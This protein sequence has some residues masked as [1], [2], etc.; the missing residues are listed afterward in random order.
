M[1]R[2]CSVTTS[3]ASSC[4]KIDFFSFELRDFSILISEVVA[5]FGGIFAIFAIV[6]SMSFVFISICFAFLLK[7]SFLL[8]A[9]SSKTSI[10]LSGKYLSV[11]KRELSST[12][13]DTA[14]SEYVTLWNFSYLDVSPFIIAFAF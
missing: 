1:I 12:A 14:S 5:L 9:L 13:N 10:A 3:T 11:I 2:I 7:S 8:A 6:F 4:P